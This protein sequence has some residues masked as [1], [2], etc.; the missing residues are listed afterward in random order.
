MDIDKYISEF[1]KK[2]AIQRYAKRTVVSYTNCLLKFLTAFR[3]YNIEEVNEK[4]I[5]TAI[6]TK[7]NHRLT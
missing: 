4:N 6:K 2:L 5:E 3:N 1:K 7:R